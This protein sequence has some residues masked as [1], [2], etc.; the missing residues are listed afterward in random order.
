M[1]LMPPSF[2]DGLWSWTTPEAVLFADHVGQRGVDGGVTQGRCGT[3]RQWPS[4]PT[5]HRD[6]P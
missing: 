5:H 3:A 6:E 4:A 1:F 2:V